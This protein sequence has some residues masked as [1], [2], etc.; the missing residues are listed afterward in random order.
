MSLYS[1]RILSISAAHGLNLAVAGLVAAT[2]VGL[3]D[4]LDLSRAWLPN[5][6]RPTSCPTS[7][8][9][10]RFGLAPRIR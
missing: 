5:L 1:D 9:A 6:H 3:P 2:S 8:R 4:R 7:K 10:K